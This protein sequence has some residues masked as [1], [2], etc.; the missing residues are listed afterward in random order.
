MDIGSQKAQGSFA[1]QVA[2]RLGETDDKQV[3]HEAVTSQLHERVQG[4]EAQ[5][6]HGDIMLEQ[7]ILS[8]N[9]QHK[10]VLENHEISLN[11][12]RTELRHQMQDQQVRDGEISELKARVETLMGLVKGKGK[13]S[14]PTPAASGAGGGNPAPPPQR[15]AAG[16]P[17]GGGDPDE[18][19][20]G[21]GR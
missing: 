6:M 13:V 10:S 17:G 15:K 7:E 4:T 5:S 3:R 2:E 14:D 11:L 1:A 21:S 8:L 9:K 12:T 18:E 20:A 19:G 16:A